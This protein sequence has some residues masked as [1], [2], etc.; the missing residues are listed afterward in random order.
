MSRQIAK[1]LALLLVAGA[2]ACTTQTTRLRDQ[3]LAP[4]ACDVQ[5][6]VQPK[7]LFL[8]HPNY[9]TAGEGIFWWQTLGPE[10][11]RRRVSLRTDGSVVKWFQIQDSPVAPKLADEERRF[12]VEVE[13]LNALFGYGKNETSRGG[14]ISEVVWKLP[15]RTVVA[16]RLEVA[17]DAQTALRSLA[18]GY[19]EFNLEP[20]SNPP[21]T[22]LPKR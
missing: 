13:R 21:T 5:L 17:G 20:A 10:N 4:Y 14:D 12:A 7:A 1:L 3:A 19:P 11:V 6:G 9:R 16:L 15:D 8:Q 18:I 22:F 2:A